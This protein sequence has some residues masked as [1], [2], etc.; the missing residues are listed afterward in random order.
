MDT[1]YKPYTHSRGAIALREMPPNS[2]TRKLMEA[3]TFDRLAE[4]VDRWALDMLANDLKGVIDDAFIPTRSGYILE[5]LKTVYL[6]V[7]EA[8]PVA[9]EF[10][11]RLTKLHYDSYVLLCAV[12]AWLNDGF[13]EDRIFSELEQADGNKIEISKIINHLKTQIV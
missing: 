1:F 2:I 7:N 8:G 11:Y 13:S 9:R 10:D 6:C 4:M 5:R 12:K 3:Q